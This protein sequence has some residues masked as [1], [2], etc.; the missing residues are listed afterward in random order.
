MNSVLMFIVL[1]IASMA[2][3]SMAMAGSPAALSSSYLQTILGG[4][5]LASRLTADLWPAFYL[6]IGLDAV[7]AAWSLVI[8]FILPARRPAAPAVGLFVA[9]SHAALAVI[10]FVVG[11]SSL[12]VG[13][14]RLALSL[15]IGFLL[16]EALGDFTWESVRLRLELDPASRSS[17]DYY[18]R[19]RYYRHID[20]T[21]KA[22][23]HLER[24]VE[25]APQR[26]EFRVALGNAYYAAG[27]FERA[28]EQLRAALQ[29]N[30]AAGDVRQFLDVVTARASS[31]H[32]LL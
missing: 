20:Q 30:P 12:P 13:L 6:F 28:A 25:L 14:A 26:F 4:T 31:D 32:T 24:A 1:A 15:L 3:A 10:S 18:T 7:S 27:Q 22:V 19:G 17:M 29:I 2:M 21:A 8:A 9:T 11:M 16:L 5:A 23:L